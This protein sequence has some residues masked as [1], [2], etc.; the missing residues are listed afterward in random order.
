MPVLLLTAAGAEFNG[1]VVVTKDEEELT[2]ASLVAFLVR[3]VV[4]AIAHR[5]NASLPHVIIAWQCSPNYHAFN[6]VCK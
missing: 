1:E 2:A 6:I 3:I 4:S 5:L